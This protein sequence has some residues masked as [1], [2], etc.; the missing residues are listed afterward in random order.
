MKGVRVYV[1]GRGER[2]PALISFAVWGGVRDADVD[3]AKGR[4]LLRE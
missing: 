1:I 4:E 2:I 3:V